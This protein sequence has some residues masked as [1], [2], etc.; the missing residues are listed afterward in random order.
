MNVLFIPDYSAAVPYQS[1]LKEALHKTGI[2]VDLADDFPLSAILSNQAKPDILHVHWTKQFF[3]HSGTV[4]FYSRFLKSL[5]RLVLIRMRGISLVWTVHN[6]VSHDSPYRRSELLFGA[7]L[8]SLSQG[9]IV[10]SEACKEQFLHEYRGIGRTKVRIIPIGHLVGAYDNSISR[11]DARQRLGLGIDDRVFLSLGHIRPYKGLQPCI[12][13]FRQLEDPSVRLLIV[14]KP[15]TEAFGDELR[16]DCAPDSRIR[17]ML[18]FVPDADLQLYLNA[19]D[20]M[21]LPFQNIFTS[22]S[23]IVR[24]ARADRGPTMTWR[25]SASSLRTK[26]G[27]PPPI[28]RPRR[29]PT[30]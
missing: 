24:R 6:L 4:R 2:H 16:R 29:W 25:A 9:V 7:F 21:I 26:S 11:D 22:A 13:A 8:I 30:V 27:S 19:A 20:V 14:G 5:V 23:L 1:Q 12:A 10:H 18:T 17:C 28:P 3:D 15:I